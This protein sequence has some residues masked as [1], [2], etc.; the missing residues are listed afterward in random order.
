[1]NLKKIGKVFMSKFVGTG[2]RSYKKK[3]LPGRGLAKVEKH[4]NANMFGPFFVGHPQGGYISINVKRCQ[5]SSGL[6]VKT[7]Y[8]D[9]MRMLVYS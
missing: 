4:W 1:M 7:L 3:N 8:C 6:I 2:P 5:S 9:I